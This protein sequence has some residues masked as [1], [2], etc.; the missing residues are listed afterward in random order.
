[1][2]ATPGTQEPAESPTGST[3][4]AQLPATGGQEENIQMM[5]QSATSFR[6]ADCDGLNAAP[7]SNRFRSN[8]EIVEKPRQ[9]IV[10]GLTIAG[11]S[12]LVS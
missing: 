8:I 9:M 5:L 1:M 6:S 7:E 12:Y 10:L 4:R 3:S 11:A 2:S